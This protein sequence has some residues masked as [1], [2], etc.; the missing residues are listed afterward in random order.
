[1]SLSCSTVSGTATTTRPARTLHPPDTKQRSAAE[2]AGSMTPTQHVIHLTALSS[3]HRHAAGHSLPAEFRLRP[4]SQAWSG[5]C[6]LGN[7]D[8]ANMQPPAQWSTAAC[9]ALSSLLLAAPML[10]CLLSL[11]AV[12]LQL[13]GAVSRRSAGEPRAVLLGSPR[14]VPPSLS[15]CSGELLLPLALSAKPPL[16]AAVREPHSI[17]ITGHS[18]RSRGPRSRARWLARCDNDR[19]RMRYESPAIQAGPA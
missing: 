17:R 7:A 19:S 9:P 4:Q 10:S 13:P 16:S 2:S 14:P 15:L 8:V 6:L 11:S 1:M 12:R 18:R 5:R 3:L